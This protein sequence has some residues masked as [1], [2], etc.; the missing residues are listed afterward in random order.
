MIV[1]AFSILAAERKTLLQ[2]HSTS[3][4]NTLLYQQYP[5]SP[6]KIGVEILTVS[7]SIHKL[8][9]LSSIHKLLRLYTSIASTGN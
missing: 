7:S 4:H 5:D 9:S 3:K 8:L 2:L 1:V 6:I